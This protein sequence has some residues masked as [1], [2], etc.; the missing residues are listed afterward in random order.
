MITNVSVP[1]RHCLCEICGYE[2]CSVAAK[3]PVNCQ[4]RECRSREWNGVKTKKLPEK[5]PALV[6]P[7]AIKVRGGND[8]FEF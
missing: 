6:L 1:A 2:W 3:I 5:K 8:D 7:K 4:N